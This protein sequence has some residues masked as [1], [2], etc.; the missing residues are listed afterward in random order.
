METVIPIMLNKDKG[1]T[2]IEVMMAIL[3]LMVGMIGLLQA[4][5]LTMEVNLRNQVREEAVYVGEK[6]MNEMR[7][8]GF[9]NIS[10]AA[11]PSQ[12]C[13]YQTYQI[14]SRL[15][16]INRTYDVTRSSRVLSI[17]DSKPATKEL[18]VL[19]NWTYKGTT[20]ENRVVA[21]ISK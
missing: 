3:I 14:P 12:S 15:R 10:V 7:G 6:V 19:V 13:S 11:I 2:L 8:R 4:I 5:N 20:Y 1:F 21:P 17:V 9:D 16:G 18:T